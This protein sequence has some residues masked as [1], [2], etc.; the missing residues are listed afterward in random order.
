MIFVARKLSVRGRAP[1]LYVSIRELPL[2]WA[3]IAALQ[4][5]RIH[6]FTLH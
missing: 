4:A 5:G 6:I 3:A 1:V 2:L